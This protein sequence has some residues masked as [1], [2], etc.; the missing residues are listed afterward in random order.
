MWPSRSFNALMISAI[1][2]MGLGAAPPYTPE[3]RSWLAP[4][5]CSSAYTM[6]RSPMQMVGSSGAN[7]SVSQMMAA[8]QQPYA[9]GGQLRREHLGVADD[10]R[11]ACDARGL[12]SDVTFDV[13]A[14]GLFLALDEEFDVHRQLAAGLQQAFHGFDQD[15]SL[16]LVVGGAARENIL[17]PHLRLKRRRLPFSA[18]VARGAGLQAGAG[19]P[20]PA[21][22]S[23]G[24]LLLAMS[25]WDRPPGLSA[26]QP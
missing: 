19:P 17:P 7:I 10:G 12:L 16:A 13:L 11:V 20:G 25:W 21:F 6:P 5:T 24:F 23:L 9:D 3:C 26:L 2:C 22:A 14:A 8:S 1:A 15:V 18:C 4:S